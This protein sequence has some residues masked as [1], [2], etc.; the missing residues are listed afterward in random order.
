MDLRQLNAL[1]AVA[2]HGT[3]SAA[4]DALATVQ[5][6]V[7]AHIARLERELGATLVDRG[8]GRLTEEGEAVAAR[9]RRVSAELDALVADLSALRHEVVGTVRV[10]MIGTT[11]RWLLPHLLTL[12][13]QRH[14]KVH[15]EA[16]EGNTTVLEPLLASGRLDLAVINLPVAASDLVFT[17]LFEEDLVLVV[18]AGDPLASRGELEPADLAHLDL[19]LPLPG[20]AFRSEIDSALGPVGITLSPRAELDGVRLL[21]SLTFEGLGPAILPAT[22]VPTYFRERWRLVRVRGMPRRRVGVAQRTRGLPSAPA[23]AL[24][25]LLHEVTSDPVARPEGLH[26]VGAVRVPEPV[27]P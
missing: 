27:R 7:S 12:V 4:A 8:A 22:A 14:P 23:R 24:L 1:V 15:L 10:G 6:N 20:T 19:L 17:P 16:V 21:A 18:Q 2:D 25:A 13:A 5:S 9:A 11:A 3:F 26:P